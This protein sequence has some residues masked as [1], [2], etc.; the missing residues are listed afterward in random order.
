MIIDDYIKALRSKDHRALAECFVEECR[1]FDYCPS[2][3]GRENSFVYGRKAVDM[4]FHN[5]FV[6]GGY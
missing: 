5:Q 2:L 3:V 4:F 6:L 1:L